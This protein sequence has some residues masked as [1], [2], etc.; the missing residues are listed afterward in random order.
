M[1]QKLTKRLRVPKTNHE[2][3]LHE[4]G[5]EVVCGVDEVG[6]GAWAGPLVAGAVVLN[7]KLYG[8]RDSKL[9]DTNE[10]QRLSK[11]IKRTCVW[12]IGE[13]SVEELD[14]LKMTKGTQ[15]GFSRA[16]KNLK[17]KIDFVLVDGF[18]FESPIPAR[19]IK[20]GDMTCSSIAAA[21]I[22]AKVH[23]DNIMR[24]MDRKIKGYNFSSHKGYGTKEHQKAISKLGPSREHRKFFKSI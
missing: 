18:P 19:A 5:F 9:L 17:K 6:R 13:V 11:K 16:V 2:E 21:S 20:K 7:K 4:Q 8:L 15:L 24:K 14:K 12:G 10:R 1:K 23:R 22:I 3:W